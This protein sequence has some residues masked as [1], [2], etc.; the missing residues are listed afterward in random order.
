MQTAPK[1]WRD[2]VSAEALR[3]DDAA[4]APWEY[5]NNG[6]G[7]DYIQDA[8]GNTVIEHIGHIDGPRIVRA[9]NEM[10]Q[11]AGILS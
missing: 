9:V 11:R 3:E 1:H 2:G 7:Y 5:R 10:A 6:R 4:P 8:R